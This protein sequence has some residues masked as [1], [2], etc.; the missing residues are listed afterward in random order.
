MVNLELKA[1]YSNLAK[2][3]KIARELQA[4]FIG[5]DQQK[6]TYFSVKKGLLKLRETQMGRDHLVWYNR[7]ANKQARKS[8]YYIYEV[9]DTAQILRILTESMGV[10]IVVRKV[11]NVYLY[12]NVRIHLDKVRALGNFIEFE[13]EI[14]DGKIRPRDKERIDSLINKFEIKTR[15]LVSQSY[16]TLLMKKK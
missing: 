13:A 7:P 2:A 4:T 8:E 6:D 5:K 15:D 16:S 3:E 10:R 11:R 9:N 1:L 14:T 12:E